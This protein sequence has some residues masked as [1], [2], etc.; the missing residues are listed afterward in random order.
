MDFG[1]RIKLEPFNIA[2]VSI[3]GE[4]MRNTPGIYGSVGKALESRGINIITDFQSERSIILALKQE[5]AL[6]AVRAL[7]ELYFGKH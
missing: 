2:L 4:G 3:V 6:S 5:D 1:F 7:H